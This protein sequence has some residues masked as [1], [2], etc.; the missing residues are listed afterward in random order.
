[1][2]VVATQRGYYGGKIQEPGDE[3]VLAPGDKPS[4]VWMQVV[5]EPPKP[6]IKRLAP[7]AVDDI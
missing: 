3:F 7:K 1:M 6:A 2:R 4:T 5:E